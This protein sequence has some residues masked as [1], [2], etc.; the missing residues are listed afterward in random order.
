[1][2]VL[3]S[4]MIASFFGPTEARMFTLH[5]SRL[6]AHLYAG[7]LMLGLDGAGKTTILYSN[8]GGNSLII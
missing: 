8:T 4:R 7:I 5:I 6:R 2:G 3:A 1:M